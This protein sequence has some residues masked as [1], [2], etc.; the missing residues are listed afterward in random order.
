MA[1]M[2]NAKF[3]ELKHIKS[4]VED[5]DAARESGDP[6]NYIPIRDDEFQSPEEQFVEYTRYLLATVLQSKKHRLYA[7]YLRVRYYL[8]PV[9]P[10]IFN[11]RE[12]LPL[13]LGI[14]HDL[15]KICGGEFSH[16]KLRN[17]L[18]IWT[19]RFEYRKALANSEH[20]YDLN[21]DRHP[22]HP[23]HPEPSAEAGQ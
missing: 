8:R 15:F 1:N 9:Y 23:V 12:P 21:G 11:E 14:H 10:D 4:R 7:D 19:Q 22:L 20:R 3:F 2:E 17:F 5:Y 18:T 13:K 6:E 16:N